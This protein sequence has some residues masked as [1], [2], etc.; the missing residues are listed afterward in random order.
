ML[1]GSVVHKTVDARGLSHQRRAVTRQTPSNPAHSLLS[2][3]PLVRLYLIHQGPAR[4]ISSNQNLR[5][6]PIATIPKRPTIVPSYPVFL[7]QHGQKDRY[8]A[9]FFPSIHP[10]PFFEI[11]NLSPSS[12]SP[13]LLRFYTSPDPRSLLSP[14]DRKDTM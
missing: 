10:L 2:H 7:V 6:C 11:G 1:W 3:T 12:P 5:Q 9:P 4:V 14:F 8:V 13:S